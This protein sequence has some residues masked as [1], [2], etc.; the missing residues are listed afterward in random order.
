MPTSMRAWL[1]VGLAVIG[2]GLA[3]YSGVR[4]VASFQA[5]APTSTSFAY[6]E[7]APCTNCPAGISIDSV[8]VQAR[9]GSTLFVIGGKLPGSADGLGSDFRILT[10]RTV[11]V[12]HPHGSQD[13]FEVV[14]ATNNGVPIPASGLA[15]TI[16]GGSLLINI[17]PAFSAPMTFE[18]GLWDGTSYTGR[19]PRVGV[20]AW[21]GKSAPTNL[22][23]AAT[24]SQAPSPQTA[25]GSID[26]T[27]MVVACPAIPSSSQV[28]PYLAFTRI[29]SSPPTPDPRTHNPVRSITAGLSASPLDVTAPYTLIAILV[30]PTDVAPTGQSRPIDGAGTEQLYI[31]F[32]GTTKHKAIRTFKNGAWNTAEDSAA[33]D[34]T[35][36]LKADQ[37]TFYWTGINSGDRF[38][39]ISAGAGATCAESGLSPQL[40]PQV[41]AQ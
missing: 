29:G 20:L 26:M 36:A 11:I 24:Q 23:G 22:N 38:G 3:G 33:G 41:P 32:D 1:A 37:V 14:S 40:A 16:S 15:A 28:P 34:L 12:F 25:G 9:Q 4:L 7:S 27:T 10:G 21:D 8:E 19:L 13:A 35:F 31:Y 2:G 17:S 30:H 18:M 5:P 39:F 6:H